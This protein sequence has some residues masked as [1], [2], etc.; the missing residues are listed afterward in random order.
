MQR[1]EHTTLPRIQPKLWIR[2]VDDIL[3]IIK[4]TKLEETQHLINNIFARIKFTREKNNNQLL[5]LDVRVEELRKKEEEHLYKIFAMNG[6]P[7]NFIC[8]CLLNRPHQEDTVRPDT[9]ATLP[10]IKN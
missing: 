5:F 2:Y 8:R 3:V 4:D 1:L 7:R 10:Y 6:Y 9:L